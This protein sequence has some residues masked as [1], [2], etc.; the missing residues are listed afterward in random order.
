MSAKERARKGRNIE[1]V[2]R[3]GGRGAVPNLVVIVAIDVN[4]TV[5]SAL[6]NGINIHHLPFRFPWVS[7]TKKQTACDLYPVPPARCL[8]PEKMCVRLARMSSNLEDTV[9]VRALSCE[10]WGNE[11]QNWQHSDDVPNL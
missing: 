1:G 10:R 11:L 4:F 7:L 3:E 2:R 8:S 5:V 9:S 6:G